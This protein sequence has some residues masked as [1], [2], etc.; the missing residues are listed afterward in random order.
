MTV[1]AANVSPEKPLFCNI[2]PVNV[3]PDN[4]ITF[5]V[6]PSYDNSI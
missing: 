4:Y 1:W 3:H 6:H 2:V 5:A